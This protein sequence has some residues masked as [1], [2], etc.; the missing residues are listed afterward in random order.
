LSIDG[1]QWCLQATALT[2]NRH[3]AALRE[4]NRRRAWLIGQLREIDAIEARPIAI[5]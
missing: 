2:R 3:I 4:E 1:D 5:N